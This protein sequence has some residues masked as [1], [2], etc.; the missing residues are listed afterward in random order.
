[1]MITTP[2][3]KKIISKKGF[4]GLM[5]ATTTPKMLG[6]KHISMHSILNLLNDFS[7]ISNNSNL[8]D[9]VLSMQSFDTSGLAT[10]LHC[11]SFS[12]DGLAV[13]F[14]VLTVLSSHSPQCLHLIAS[15]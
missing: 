1:M 10:L 9:I 14:G 11:E 13:V 5:L 3:N 12:L 8:A 7:T 15:S 6:K 4:E 2:P